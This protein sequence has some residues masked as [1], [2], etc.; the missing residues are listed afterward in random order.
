MWSLW[1]EY[2][3]NSQRLAGNPANSTTPGTLT[4]VCVAVVESPCC[5]GVAVFVLL[6]VLTV[7]V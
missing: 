1:S 4:V 7:H 2:L 3:Q 5:C 6:L